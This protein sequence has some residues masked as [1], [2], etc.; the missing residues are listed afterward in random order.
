MVFNLGQTCD[1]I[2]LNHVYTFTNHLYNGLN[3]QTTITSRGGWVKS[4]WTYC[5]MT[6]TTIQ[7]T[8]HVV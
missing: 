2:T 8:I 6:Q 1:N 4:A 7:S 3:H 5:H